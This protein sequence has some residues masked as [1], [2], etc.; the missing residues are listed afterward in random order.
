MRP[1]LKIGEVLIGKLDF[2]RHADIDEEVELKN[3]QWQC[4]SCEAVNEAGTRG[5]MER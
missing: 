5:L 3:E 4:A 2:G 1:D